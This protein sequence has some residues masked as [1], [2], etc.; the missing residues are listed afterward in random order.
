MLASVYGGRKVVA[1]SATRLVLPETRHK[2]QDT[3]QPEENKDGISFIV[4][5]FLKIVP[6]SETRVCKALRSKFFAAELTKT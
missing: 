3:H 6:R 4:A 2:T 5:Y 1:D